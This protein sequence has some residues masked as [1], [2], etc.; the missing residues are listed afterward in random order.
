MKDRIA[1][2]GHPLIQAL[3]PTTIE[4]TTEEHLTERG[5]CIVGVGADRG[6]SGLNGEVKEAIRRAGSRL[7]VRIVVGSDSYE[8][9]AVGDPR[10]SLTHPN[11]MVLRMS[12]F[13]SDRTLGVGAS[14]AAKDIPR[15]MV[16][17]LKAPVTTG[18]LEVEVS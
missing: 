4:I 14:A 10:L 13:I 8:V 15:R 17:S 6:C 5:D 3:H 7:T 1:F 16:A 2:H 18:Y 11:D 12:H 9:K